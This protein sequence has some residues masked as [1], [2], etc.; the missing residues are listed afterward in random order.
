MICYNVLYIKMTSSA[1]LDDSS[2][3]AIALSGWKENIERKRARKKHI[4]L[5]YI[6]LSLS[7]SFFP[8]LFPIQPI[9]CEK[10][11]YSHSLPSSSSISLVLQNHQNIY[12][13][14]SSHS[15]WKTNRTHHNYTDTIIHYTEQ[16][17]PDGYKI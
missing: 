17:Q 4:I 12:I 15:R 16:R 13:Y 8:S 14:I 3:Y 9:V 10:G 6:S 1:L 5:Y 7:L 2:L 11:N